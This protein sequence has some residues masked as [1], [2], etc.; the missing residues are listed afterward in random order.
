VTQI[1]AGQFDDF[2]RAGLLA[3]E[4]QTLGVDSDDIQKFVLNAPGQ[5]DRYPIGG[6]EDADPTARG[7]ETGAATGA[8]LGG[9]A[10]SRWEPPPF[11]SWGRGGS[12][13][14]GH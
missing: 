13:G 4:L 1:L 12:S 5:H 9:A 6:D 11:P 14:L 2:E 8:A 3:T 10:G 7:G